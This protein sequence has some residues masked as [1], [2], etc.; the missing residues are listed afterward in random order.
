MA[1]LCPGYFLVNFE[2]FDDFLRPLKWC[3]RQWSLYF[4]RHLN[5]SVYFHI[6]ASS[7]CHIGI[8]NYYC[9][10]GTKL[11]VL[12]R[13]A[14]D[15]IQWVVSTH[16]FDIQLLALASTPLLCIAMTELSTQEITELG[17]EEDYFPLE[18]IVF[19]PSG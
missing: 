4:G 2:T 13:K 3:Q 11:R 7:C 8:G 12:Q 17:S 18:I 1:T 15:Y 16:Q 10:K 5:V 19:S 14:E 6:L 9:K